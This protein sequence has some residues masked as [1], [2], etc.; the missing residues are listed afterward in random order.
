MLTSLIPIRIG[1]TFSTRRCY[2]ERPGLTL[3][4]RGSCLYRPFLTPCHHWSRPISLFYP[5]L[6]SP[7]A[8]DGL[9][10]LIRMSCPG[11]RCHVNPHDRC[12]TATHSMGQ[13]VPNDRVTTIG[14]ITVHRIDRLKGTTWRIFPPNQCLMFLVLQNPDVMTPTTERSVVVWRGTGLASGLWLPPGSFLPLSCRHGPRS[15][16]SWLLTN[17]Q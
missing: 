4:M 17:D 13:R 6:P 15:I 11:Y 5:H 3:R 1:C 2:P 7:T 12:L 10:R 14:C 8:S 9:A 16:L